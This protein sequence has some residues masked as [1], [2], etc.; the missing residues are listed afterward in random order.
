L[1]DLDPICEGRVWTGGQAKDLHLVD[2]HGDFVDAIK[3]AAE[4]GGLPVDDNYLIPVVN[5]SAKRNGYILPQPFEEVQEI[6]R[7]LSKERFQ[8][9]FGRPLW[10]LPYQFKIW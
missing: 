4:L 9:M 1:D 2:S 5:L 7:L 6:G 10:F 3:K 8:E